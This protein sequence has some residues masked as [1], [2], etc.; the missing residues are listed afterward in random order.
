MTSHGT[1]RTR[2]PRST[3]RRVLLYA[4]SLG[5][6]VLVAAGLWLGITAFLVRGEVTA[7]QGGLTQLQAQIESGDLQAAEQTSSALQRHANR[8]H[9]LTSGPAWATAAALPYVGEPLE[10]VRGATSAAAELAD[11]GLAG[12]IDAAASL[13]PEDLRRPD[14]SVAIDQIIAAAPSIAE[15]NTATAHALGTIESLPQRTWLRT[16]DTARDRLQEQLSSLSGTLQSADR[17]ARI[18]PVLLGANA[19][20]R[21]FIGFQNDAEARG[22]GGLP[23]AFAIAVVDKGRFTFTNFESDDFLHTTETNL[24][25]GRDFAL[26]YA[27]MAP[28]S[29]YVNTNISAHFPYAA[30]IWAAMWEAKT[31]EHVDAAIAVD[32]TALSYLLRATGPT[33]LADGTTLS[34][35]DVV[36]LTQSTAYTRFGDDQDARKQFL[37]D[38]ARAA[39][40]HLL[41][42]GTD[43]TALLK[44]AAKAAGERRLLIWSSDNA[45]QHELA[46]TS[47]SG[48]IPVTPDPYSGFTVNNAGG[49]KLD[50]YLDRSMSWSASGCGP[51]RTVSATLVL[52]NNGPTSGLTSYVD[53][54]LDRPDY[55]VQPGDNAELVSYYATAGSTLV[56]ATIDG[57]PVQAPKILAEQGHPLFRI[58]VELPTGQPRTV[59]FTIEEPNTGDPLTILRQPLVRPMTVDVVQP[60]CG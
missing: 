44:Q 13:R 40:E 9:S 16:A 28:T 58:G 8:A 21:V 46:G 34:S 18:A 45:V 53:G 29:L 41:D 1:R 15:A 7:L 4:V 33:Q 23:G 27:P 54:R 36:E 17:A 37:T 3:R 31:G 30:R 51:T 56:S 10:T 47:L 19:P 25:L 52:T 42:P 26:A 48:A 14:G 22:T 49:N 12:V 50:Y 35:D 32:P 57:I 20:Q 24:D 11:H 59:A 43:E 55:P 39:S 6:A 5:W 2:R 38:V 60:D